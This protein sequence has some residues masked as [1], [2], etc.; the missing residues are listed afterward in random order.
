MGFRCDWR[1]LRVAFI[2]L[3]RQ[4]LRLVRNRR[5]LIRGSSTRWPLYNLV[6]HHRDG[7]I[8]AQ[9]PWVPRSSWG[10]NTSPGDLKPPFLAEARAEGKNASISTV[11][12][13]GKH[14]NTGWAIGLVGEGRRRKRH[15]RAV[16]LYDR[17]IG[18]RVFIHAFIFMFIY[19]KR[20]RKPS[21][22][23]SE[24]IPL[25]TATNSCVLFFGCWRL[26]I[27]MVIVVRLDLRHLFGLVN[28]IRLE[29]GEVFI[30]RDM[31]LMLDWTHASFRIT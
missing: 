17:A 4:I 25:T 28:G 21:H 15:T 30:P 6:A 16:R 3:H 19:R 10:D 24:L 29:E 5:V 9:P 31:G 2:F 8:N 22:E 23:E 12:R 13:L 14:R 27:M 18:C 1:S 20:Q 26:E 7:G 11:K